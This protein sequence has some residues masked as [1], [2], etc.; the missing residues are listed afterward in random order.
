MKPILPLA[1]LALAVLAS[2]VAAQDAGFDRPLIV[3][4]GRGVAERTADDFFVSGELRVEGADQ[5]AALRAIEA[6]RVRLADGLGDMDGLTAGRLLTQGLSVEA[7][8]RDDCSEVRRD[9]E[10]CPTAAY[11][12]RISFTFKGRPVDQAGNAGSLA[13][14]LGATSVGAAGIEVEDMAALRA[15]AN[16]LA[17]ADARRQAETLARA[18][19]Q[20]ITGVVRVQDRNARLGD[21]ESGM[22]EEIV[23]T[24]SR[25]RPTVAIPLAYPPVSVEQRVT[26]VFSV[27]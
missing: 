1:V 23:V 12:A 19:G 8:G 17:V 20:R 7:I 14:E 6:A 2:P 24:G 9:Q 4:E 22:V 16:G 13:A 25:I 5:L 18:A 11:S 15:E 21:N 27:E 10:A 26:V 3:V